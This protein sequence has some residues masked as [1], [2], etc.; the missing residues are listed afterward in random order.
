[1]LL[2]QNYRTHRGEM[3]D[4]NYQCKGKNLKQNYSA[5]SMSQ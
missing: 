5:T 1:M 2:G 3:R 4:D